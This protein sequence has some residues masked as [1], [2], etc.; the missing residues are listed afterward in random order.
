MTLASTA[1]EKRKVTCYSDFMANQFKVGDVVRLKSGSPAMT[2]TD[3]YGDGQLGCV[4]FVGNEQK[5]GSY[6]RAALEPAEQ[7]PKHPSGGGPQS[8][9]AR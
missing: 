7:Q 6:P 8:W 3:N 2:V 1:I 4:W 5:G 9:M